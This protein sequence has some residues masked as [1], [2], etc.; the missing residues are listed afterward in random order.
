MALKPGTT[1]NNPDG[2]TESMVEK[3]GKTSRDEFGKE[4]DFSNPD[5]RMLFASIL[6]GAV[7]HLQKHHDAFKVEVELPGGLTAN[8]EAKEIQ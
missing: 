6:K 8:G 4:G 3:M 5:L 1:I 7:R 2:F